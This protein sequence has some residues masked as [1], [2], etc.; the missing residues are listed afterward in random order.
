MPNVGPALTPE[1]LEAMHDWIRFG[2]PRDQVVEGTS[3]LLGTC[4]PPDTPLKVAP[5]PDPPLMG[6]GVQFL[7]T[8]WD[9][10]ADSEN[11]VCFATYYDFTQNPDLVPA[12]FRVPCPGLR[13]RQQPVRG[14]LLLPP[15]EPAAGRAVASQHHPHLQR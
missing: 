6:T 14:V 15:A 10:P 3:A 11:E 2:A 9:L 13:R 1:H 4:L 5:P 7:S 8:A 12:E